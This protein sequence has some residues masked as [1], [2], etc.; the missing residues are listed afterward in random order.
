MLNVK[1]SPIVIIGMHRSGTILLTKILGTNNDVFW[2]SK[3]GKINNES[4]FFQ[5][6]NKTLLQSANANWD[7]PEILDY[8]DDFYYQQS[9]N[10][11]TNILNSYKT[12]DYWGQKKL[13]GENFQTT[14]RK[15]GWKDPRTTLLLDVWKKIFPQMKVIHIYRNPLDIA[16]SLKKRQIKYEKTSIEQLNQNKKLAYSGGVSF[17]VKSLSEGLKLWEYHTKKAFEFDG[18][19]IHIPYE[20][21]LEKSTDILKEISDFLKMDL[22]LNF[23]FKIDSSRAGAYKNEIIDEF[24]NSAIVQKLKYQI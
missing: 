4:F 1:E 23:D 16:L 6:I 12:F 18:D 11:I 17:R 14:E 9:T 8:C 3:L 5:S 13:V 15:W 21:L 22:T 2:G 10:Y 19:I 20:N 24:R 7:C